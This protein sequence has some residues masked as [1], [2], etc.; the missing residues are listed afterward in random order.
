[1]IGP[2]IQ[3]ILWLKGRN[4]SRRKYLILNDVIES[5]VEDGSGSKIKIV[6]AQLTSVICLQGEKRWSAPVYSAANTTY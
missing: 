3:L 5:I 1:M 2:E 4:K 6:A